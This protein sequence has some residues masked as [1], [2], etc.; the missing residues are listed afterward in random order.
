MRTLVTG[1]TGLVG[2]ALVPRLEGAVVLSRD[3]EHARR[4]LPGVEAHAWSPVAGP[5]PA[6]ALRDIDVVFNLAGEPLAE[7]HWTADK[8]RRIRD[9]RVLGTRNLVAGLAAQP[10]RARVLVS[11][12]AV[13]YYGDRGDEELDETSPAGHGFLAE[14]CAAWE[15]EAMAAEAL[16]IRAVC[17]R[18]G[19]VLAREGGALA[20]MLPPFRL[21]AGGKVGNGRQ[22]MSFVHIDDVVGI[23]LHASREPSCRGAMNAVAP[24]PVTN[25]EFTRALAQAL[26]RPAF[27]AVPKA[28]LWLALGE[29]SQ[30]LTSSQ[31]VFPRV[32]ERTGYAFRY[33]EL[34]TALAAMLTAP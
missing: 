21:G 8:K 5:P 14:V 6:A 32:A 22:W 23:L 18:L 26:H 29:M 17:V 7:G 16:G 24:G 19:I 1:A 20:K 12:S 30:I 10:S 3:P 4:A 2:K 11:A 33:P 31:R 34:P 27:L 28:A 25:A 9:S 13:G 15:G